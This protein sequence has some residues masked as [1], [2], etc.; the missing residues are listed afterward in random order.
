[1][2][3]KDGDVM[4]NLDG[5][6]LNGEDIQDAPNLSPKEDL[7]VNTCPITK[8]E[9]IKALWRIRTGKATG[10]YQLPSEVLKINLENTYDLL[11]G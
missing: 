8:D 3:D 7:D 2:K 5:P 10:P 9:I 6:L 4:K 1:M 11:I